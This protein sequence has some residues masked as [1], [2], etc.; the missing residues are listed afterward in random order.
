MG[1]KL[2]KCRRPTV[3]WERAEVWRGE[4]R[5]R[6]I[7]IPT[8]SQLLSMGAVKFQMLREKLS[9]YLKTYLLKYKS[10]YS[11]FS[12]LGET[13]QYQKNEQEPSHS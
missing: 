13:Q 1:W 9:R 8:L 12:L 2:Y 5:R 7:L 10:V 11:N 3:T 6:G 4:E